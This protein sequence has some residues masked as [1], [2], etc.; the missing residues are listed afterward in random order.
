[1]GL[2]SDLG[3]YSAT[4]LRSLL[5]RKEISASE[6]MRETW[7]TVDRWEPRVSAFITPLRERAMAQAPALDRKPTSR[8]LPLFGLPFTVKDTIEVAGVRSTAGSRLLADHVPDASSSV[9]AAIIDAGAIP[10]AKTNCSEFGIGNLEAWSPVGGQTRN[11]WDPSRTPGG[12]SGGDSAAVASGMSTFGIGTDYGGSIRFPAHCTG[13]AGLRPTPGRLGSDSQLPQHSSVTRGSEVSRVQRD[14]QTAGFLAR[15]VSDLALLLSVTGGP[16]QPT[17]P[18]TR[19]AWF[20]DDVSPEVAA[21]VEAAAD[22]LRDAGLTVTETNVF[23]PVR[24][25]SLLA[26]LRAAEGLPEIEWLSRG[27]R[28]LLSPLVRDQV[29]RPIVPLREGAGSEIQTLRARIDAFLTDCPVVVMPVAADVAF[30]ITTD[31]PDRSALD[32]STRLVTLLRL[33]AVVVPFGTSATGLPIGVQVVARE[34][35]DEDALAAA[36]I[37]EAAFGRFRPTRKERTT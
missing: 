2:L 6:L 10:I 37:L 22:T 32:R 8:I 30:E 35:H 14:L 34:G 23:E 13:I 17:S 33:P 3:S 9:V 15:S 31:Q 7:A 18:L 20:V 25:A 19:A 16:R 12:S 36:G 24:G 27:R 4:E 29:E 5:D 21:T 26:E 1:M 11:P 28:D